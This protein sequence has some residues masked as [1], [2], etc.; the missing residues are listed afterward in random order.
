MKAFSLVIVA[1]MVVSCAHGQDEIDPDPPGPGGEIPGLP[2]PLP[3]L[4]L[5]PHK[6][7]L[8]LGESQ[9]LTATLLSSSGTP[10]ANWTVEFAVAGD[11]KVLTSVLNAT[12]DANG[13][14]TLTVESPDTPGG[15]VVVAIAFDEFGA[16]VG[17]SPAKIFWY[18]HDRHMAYEHE[19]S[20][21]KHKH[22]KHH[23]CVGPAAV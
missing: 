3:K 10:I 6:S 19:K 18:V 2:D 16:K 20:W 22:G 12:T 8:K 13:Q 23:R 7:Y 17:C 5:S 1:L 21:G 15:V 11:C 9:T 4:T 14:A